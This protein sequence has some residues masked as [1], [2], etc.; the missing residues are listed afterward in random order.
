VSDESFARFDKARAAV[1]T[2]PE[3]IDAAALQT[4]LTSLLQG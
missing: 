4:E 1:A 2:S 3:E